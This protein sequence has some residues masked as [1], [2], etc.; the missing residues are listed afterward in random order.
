VYGQ[1]FDRVVYE[2]MLQN[3][4]GSALPTNVYLT[5]PLK[6]YVR[7]LPDLELEMNLERRACHLWMIRWC[8]S[9]PILTRCEI[10]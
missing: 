5:V 7:D 3:P 1:G 6:V 9:K 10:L 2:A 4:V 8:S